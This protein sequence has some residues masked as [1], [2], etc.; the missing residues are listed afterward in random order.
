MTTFIE[1]V[2]FGVAQQ[3]EQTTLYEGL[4]ELEPRCEE[5]PPIKVAQG[6]FH[7]MGFPYEGVPLVG[8]IYR[9]TSHGGIPAA[10]ITCDEVSS[11]GLYRG[12][13]IVA[14]PL[15]GEV[16]DVEPTFGGL[17]PGRVL[18]E[19]ACSRGT[20]G[21]IPRCGTLPWEPTTT[22]TALRRGYGGEEFQALGPTTSCATSGVKTDRKLEDVRRTLANIPVESIKTLAL[23]RFSP[24]PSSSRRCGITGGP[25][26]RCHII[27]AMITIVE[28]E[29]NRSGS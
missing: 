6:E 2:R 12:G 17:H 28:R 1:D 19:R 14:A 16:L 7:F 18:P 25:I 4:Q 15:Q 8:A 22:G 20:S 26:P 5:Y 23:I 13:E 11:N 27:G 10:I 21:E 29:T 3:F 24:T 9:G